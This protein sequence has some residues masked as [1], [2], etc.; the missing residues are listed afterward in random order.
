MFT[1]HKIILIIFKNDFCNHSHSVCLHLESIKQTSSFLFCVK[2]LSHKNIFHTFP[3]KL[4]KTF[5]KTFVPDS[6]LIK[7]ER[8]QTLEQIISCEF[9]E[10]FKNKCPSF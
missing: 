1:K 6:P 5:W 2:S 10:I 9:S 3:R 7:E 4:R 8:L